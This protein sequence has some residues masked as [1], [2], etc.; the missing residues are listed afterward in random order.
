[1]TTLKKICKALDLEMA[2][3]FAA[4]N[5]HVFDMDR[6]KK[7][8]KTAADLNPTLYKAFGEIIRFARQIK[9]ID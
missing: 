4:D 1:M 9:F 7:R 2:I 5:V 8:Y 3:L 6:L